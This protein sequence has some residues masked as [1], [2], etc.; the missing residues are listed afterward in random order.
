VEHISSLVLIAGLSG[1]GNSTAID[2]LEDLGYYA[3]DNLPVPLLP[4]LIELSKA[5]PTKYGRTALLLDIH[6]KDRLDELMAF[7]PKCDRKKIQ[8]VFL[9]AAND[10]I[11]R[12]Y[13]ETR[14]P[15][16]GFDAA[17]DKSL[18]DTIQRERTLLLPLKHIANYIIDS[19]NLSVHE[20]KRQIREYA[21]TISSGA[22]HTI[23]VNFMSF[24]FKFGLPAD[25][26]LVADVRF[27]PNPYFVN[28]LRSKTGHDQSVADFVVKSDEASGFIKR[29]VDLIN[30]LIPLY[31]FEGKS[32]L[33][34][35]IG[36][37]GGRHRSVAIAEE[38]SKVVLSDNCLISVKHRD[39]EKP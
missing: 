15:H 37:T 16:P 14:R 10:I 33:N 34:I 4:S 23:R 38:L 18:E 32:Y 20:L 1:A 29:Y 28:E 5:S 8:I 11:I 25:C 24:G 9:D 26:D 36:C 17:R 7:L 35:G 13:S 21:A 39:L 30:F 19:S 3:I 22:W 27:L 6:S 31:A 12:R 2:S